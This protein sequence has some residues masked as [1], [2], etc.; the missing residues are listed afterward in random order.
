MRIAV[1]SVAQ[2]SPFV[3]ALSAPSKGASS[4]S[5]PQPYWRGSHG[6]TA[7]HPVPSHPNFRTV[8][9]PFTGGCRI[10]LPQLPAKQ[11]PV[12]SPLF[13]CCSPILTW[14]IC[15]TFCFRP[16]LSFRHNRPASPPFAFSAAAQPALDASEHFRRLAK[17]THPLPAIPRHGSDPLSYN[18]Q[19]YRGCSNSQSYRRG[20]STLAL[21]ICS[22]ALPALPENVMP[23]S[24]YVHTPINN[25]SSSFA[26]LLS[27]PIGVHVHTLFNPGH[28]YWPHRVRA[29]NPPPATISSRTKVPSSRTSNSRSWKQQIIATELPRG[30]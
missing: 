30:Q 12:S 16:T 7:R 28:C 6:A 29:P 20:P 8:T 15:L 22:T 5:L 18:D 19:L 13:L 24:R 25:Q 1:A 4:K 26:V 17:Q 2:R 27:Q 23:P 21:L 11:P 14:L 9:R 3:D 10:G